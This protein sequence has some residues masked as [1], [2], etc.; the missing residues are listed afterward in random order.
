MVYTHYKS[1][2]ALLTQ[3]EHKECESCKF[4]THIVTLWHTFFKKMLIFRE[5]DFFED[6]REMN[7]VGSIDGFSFNSFQIGANEHY[8][9][10]DE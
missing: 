8:F 9:Y 3:S 5:N 7:F 10:V 6:S 2:P 1:V 4:A